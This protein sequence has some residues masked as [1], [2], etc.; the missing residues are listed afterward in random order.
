M[1]SRSMA[2]IIS[3]VVSCRSDPT[4]AVMITSVR[5]VPN[6]R[7]SNLGVPVISRLEDPTRERQFQ[8]GSVDEAGRRRPVGA[9]NS[10]V[11]VDQGRDFV[12]WRGSSVEPMIVS[13]MIQRWLK[14]SG[15][16]AIRCAGRS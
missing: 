10:D 7:P 15:R 5:L 8:S 3:S 12:P 13:W 9:R 1:A 2:V 11:V 14:C 16:W 4:A 6:D